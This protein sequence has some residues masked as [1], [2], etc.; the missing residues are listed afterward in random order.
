MVEYAHCT[1]YFHQVGSLESILLVEFDCILYKPQ[2]KKCTD[3]F[4]VKG[5]MLEEMWR[6]AGSSFPYILEL[7][8]C[9]SYWQEV[10]QNISGNGIDSSF[11]TTYWGN[12][13]ANLL[14][15]DKSTKILLAASKRA[16]TRKW[17]QT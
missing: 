16:I 9:S 17:L 12:I 11:S 2:V 10:I 15:R 7:P 3:R 5:P 14:G 4:D 8:S 13:A 6:T 1:V